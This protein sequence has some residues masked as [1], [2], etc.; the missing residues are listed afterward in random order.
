MTLAKDKDGYCIRL[1]EAEW[2]Y[3]FRGHKS[4]LSRSV[5]SSK[6]CGCL[7]VMFVP[8]REESKK[9]ATTLTEKLNTKATQ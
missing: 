1:S 8:C 4:V 6:G 3:L 7:T 9:C 2:T 5:G